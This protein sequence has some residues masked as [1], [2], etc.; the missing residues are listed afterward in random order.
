MDGVFSI[1]LHLSSVKPECIPEASATRYTSRG[2]G[3]A[4]IP[5]AS[6]SAWSNFAFPRPREVLGA[7]PHSRV[8]AP[9]PVPLLRLPFP[10]QQGWLST[11]RQG[12]TFGPLRVHSDVQTVRLS[13]ARP[14]TGP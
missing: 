7:D 10:A 4:C 11:C 8:H 2:P 5:E 14:M 13:A 6:A 9:P 1:C 3:N 12:A